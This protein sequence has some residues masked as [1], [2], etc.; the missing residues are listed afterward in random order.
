MWGT[1]FST[2]SAKRHNFKENINFKS[3]NT[4]WFSFGLNI[5]DWKTLNN[6]EFASKVASF[7]RYLHPDICC[8]MS[9]TFWFLRQIL[10]FIRPKS[11]LVNNWLTSKPK[12]NLRNQTNQTKPNILNQ[13]VLWLESSYFLWKHST[14]GSVVSLAMLY[15]QYTLI[16]P[17]LHQWGPTL[18]RL[19]KPCMCCSI[20][21]C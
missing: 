10:I 7:Y 1:S 8:K 12:P 15:F 16:S 6:K 13:H 21:F 17:S 4:L 14:L 11:T 19:F 9:W 18:S 5:S 3:K 20:N 2:S